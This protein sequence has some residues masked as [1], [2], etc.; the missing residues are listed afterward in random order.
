VWRDSKTSVSGMCVTL[1]QFPDTTPVTP[2]EVDSELGL[3]IG[4]SSKVFVPINKRTDEYRIGTQLYRS[5]DCMYIHN[6]EIL[7][8]ERRKGHFIR[9]LEMLWNLGFTIKVFD[10]TDR[11]CEELK[12]RGFVETN[13]QNPDSPTPDLV[14][15]M[16]KEPPPA[17]P[18]IG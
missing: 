13:E 16:V 12:V 1:D 6:F 5:G 10:P 18:G 3:K 4:L 2:I 15:V 9:L 17:P 8:S 11:T 14:V 7:K